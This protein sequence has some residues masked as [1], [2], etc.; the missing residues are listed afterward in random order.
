MEKISEVTDGYI[1][2]VKDEEPKA[3]KV[4]L[5][6]CEDWQE[7]FSKLANKKCTAKGCHGRGYVGF[8]ETEQGKMP[9]GC[10]A[11]RCSIYNLRILQR[12]QRIN[13]MKKK[14]EEKKGKVENDT[15]NT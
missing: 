2:E 9:V 11:K 6:T 13:Q 3:K 7:F 12:H 14:Q 8:K 4:S 1:S 15:N 5:E 10:T